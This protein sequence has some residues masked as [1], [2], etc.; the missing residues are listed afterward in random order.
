MLKEDKLKDQLSMQIDNSEQSNQKFL[1][2]NSDTPF[3]LVTFL[4]SCCMLFLFVYTSMNRIFYPFDLEWMEGGM[5]LHGLRIMEGKN[6]YV[7]PSSD[8]IPFIYP[9]LYSWLLAIGGWIW[10]LDYPIGRGISFVST[11]LATGA[12]IMI[13]RIEKISWPICLSIGAMFLSTYENSGTFMDVVRTDSLA[14]ALLAWSL[15]CIRIQ[16]VCFGGLLLCLAFLA[17]HNVAVFGFPIVIWLWRTHGIKSAVLFSVSSAIPAV[18]I[19]I[20]LQYQSDG[21]FLKYILDVPSVHPFVS[22]RFFWLAPYE[23]I[24]GL[25]IGIFSLFVI[26]EI[27]KNNG[28]NEPKQ[29]FINISKTNICLVLILFFTV[30]F[31][32][33]FHL[34]IRDT[35]LSGFHKNQQREI[36]QCISSIPLLLGFLGMLWQ[37]KTILFRHM[38]WSSCFVVAFLFCCIMRGHHGGYMNVLMPGFWFLA[39]VIGLF[40]HQLSQWKHGQKMISFLVLIQLWTGQWEPHLY[41]PT[42]TDIEQGHNHIEKL[43]ELQP[44]ILSPFSPWYAYKAGHPPTFHLIALWDIDHSGGV[45]HPYVQNI[46]NDISDGRWSALILAN[47][48]FDFGRKKYYNQKQ[49]LSRQQMAV[50]PKI[51]WREQS[52]FIFYPSASKE[53]K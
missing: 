11:L 50:K 51:G 34:W 13:G 27:T 2:A 30:W 18:L 3:V 5:L 19:T 7:E 49:R 17:K 36:A 21:F 29:L 15:L 9:P 23:M 14:L 6:L 20:F 4:S 22:S 47:D 40:F 53:S 41:I 10:E 43:K 39:L 45:L 1:V 42:T 16:Y 8:F 25:C 31:H 26:I 28:W 12:L 38:L 24:S 46:R 35:F 32:D 52:K 37:G 48:Q 44:P 33:V